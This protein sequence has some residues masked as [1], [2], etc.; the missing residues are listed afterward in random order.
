L[1]HCRAP[2]GEGGANRSCYC[3]ACDDVE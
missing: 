3:L 2:I 1:F